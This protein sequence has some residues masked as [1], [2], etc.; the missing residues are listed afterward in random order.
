MKEILLGLNNISFN[1]PS[2][3][4][5]I[6]KNI[7]Y[8]I[9]KE[10][11][12][13]LL[14]HNGSGKSSL[15]K[16]LDGRYQLTSGEIIS[17]KLNPKIHTL[18]QD[19]R[20]SLFGSLT[21]LENCLLV[22]QTSKSKFL[23][24]SNAYDRNFFIN[25]LHDFNQELVQKLDV[26]V[27]NLSGGQQQALVLA[28]SILHAPEILLLDEHTSALDPKASMKLMAITA[29][30]AQKYGI[31]CVLSTHD[32]ALALKYGNRILALAD[33]EIA[34]CIEFEQKKFLKVQDLLEICY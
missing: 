9:H 31:T 28:L 13:I 7:N 14:G 6:L 22:Q 26:M 23:Q 4:K 17:A 2:L 24:I 11:F 20:E 33:G 5:P 34:H 8:N 25:Y 10:D 32:L 16:I 12:I 3:S 27:A 21:V 15:L 1:L 19:N 30:A 18:T 29:K